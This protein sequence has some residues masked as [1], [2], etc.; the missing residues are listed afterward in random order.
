MGLRPLHM[1]F[2]ALYFGL[3]RLY[4]CLQF[5]DRHGI[6]VLF[7]KL[8]QRVARLAWEEVVQIHILNR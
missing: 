4:A 6:E 3:E 8:D 7:G 2:N 5:L 1:G